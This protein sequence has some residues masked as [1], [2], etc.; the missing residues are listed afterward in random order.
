MAAHQRPC[1]RCGGS[2]RFFLVARPRNGGAPFWLCNQCRH[3]EAADASAPLITEPLRRL[4]PDEIRQAQRGYAAAAEWCAL[5]LWTPDGRPALEYLYA[6]GL[7][8]ETIHRARLGYHPD[9]YR[10]GVG[11]A[12]WHRDRDAYDGARLGGLIAPQGQPKSLLRGA[13]T[14]PY[15]HGGVC[16]LL[17]TRQLGD[18]RKGATYRSPGG[19]A[20]YAGGAP[21]LYGA[22]LLT[23]PEV[24]T[25]LLTEGEFKALLPAQHGIPAVAQPGVGY[26]PQAVVPSL[27]G[28]TVVVCYDVE[29]RR[30][31]FQMSP[32]EAWTLRAVGRLTGID[33]QERIGQTHK[34][35]GEITGK[36][37]STEEQ[38][39]QIVQ[40]EALQQQLESLRSQLEA[41][42]QLRISVKVLRLPRAPDE[43]KI[44]LDGFILRHGADALRDLVKRAEDGRLWHE[45]HHGGGY[46]Y[47]RG[48]MHNGQPVANYQAR[49]TET[50]HMCDGQETTAIQRL[51][52][53]TPSGE[54]LAVD[55]PAEEWADD[56]S[57]R[58]AIRVGLREGTF[59][60]DPRE[61][62]RAI[63]LLSNQGDPPHTRTVY[64]AT[65]WE[66]IAGRWHFLS[67]DGAIHA[68]GMTPNVRAE[69][70]PEAPGN[71]YALCAEGSAA[72]GARAW[73]RFLRGDVCPQPLALVLAAQA[74]LPLIHR[75]AGN[76]ARSMTW[77]YHQSGS[78]KTALVRATTLAL[79]GPLFTAERGDGRP[80]AKW[81]GTSTGFGL[82]VFYYRDLPVLIDDYKKDMIDEK[83]FKRFLH[84]YSEGASRSRATK[85]LGLDRSRPARCIVFSTAEDIPTG[86]PGMQA[87]LLSMELKPESVDPDALAAL[88]RAGA[89]GHLAAFWRGFVQ[90]LARALDQRGEH[91]LR[92]ELATLI[93]ADDDTLAG[94]KRAVGTLRQ[95]RLAW[96]V[97]SRWLQ[98]A[99]YL[100]AAEAQQLDAAHLETRSL[101]ASVLEARQQENRPS[102]IFLAVL[103]ELLT[104]GEL[105]VEDRAMPCPRCG[106]ALTRSSDG[107]FCTG[108][109]GE[110]ELPCTYHLRAERIIGFRC[111][112]GVGIYAN[113]AFQAV[114]RVRNDQR[115]S[116][117]YSSGAIWQ[118]LEAD[119]ALVA[120]DKKRG[121]PTVTRRN[122]AHLGADGK[123]TPTS[124]LLL[125]PEALPLGDREAESESHVQTMR[126]QRS[127]DSEG[128]AAQPD[129]E[130]WDDMSCDPVSS[131]GH[132]GDPRSEAPRD[133][134]AQDRRD[135]T[136]S[137]ACDPGFAAAERAESQQDR[138][139]R[140]NLTLHDE[141]K[142]TQPVRRRKGGALPPGTYELLP[143]ESPDE[144]AEP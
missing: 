15:W 141:S 37:Q 76:A 111:A 117:T 9:T 98:T 113:K 27:A 1:P 41:L 124:V 128:D 81:D 107:W 21:T 70:D 77:L 105:V 50:V 72:E 144:G 12:L 23:D 14:I 2:D 85:L 97:L 71:H 73:L 115:Q 137:H 13:I 114:S 45:L 140:M 8:A 51:A 28:K 122:P 61:V 102:Q 47:D 106:G 118:Q 32:G 11:P 109:V 10:D 25:V 63:R 96:L 17:R 6:R 64:T 108:T 48:G 66:A 104:S 82:V 134:P 103:A 59:D 36:K 68:E 135:D 4:T 60:D 62:L 33:L 54:R 139:D 91:G 127:R 65:G 120:T 133:S 43:P 53:Q 86:D 67:S 42:Q 138:R 34:A 24:R 88:Q 79:Y 94:H 52:L 99:G 112:D 39:L 56:R 100:S 116:F 26:L 19:V 123:G 110:R 16:T 87:R 75:F 35:L 57:A 84:N 143:L 132:P 22:D 40:L 30:D 142:N 69:I 92:A 95:N 101:L 130:S 90:E 55:V 126:S 38:A 129:A 119:G 3:Y 80:V 20:L 58:Q 121:R 44:D 83:H 89:A 49:I 18:G 131:H 7:S 93:S 29:G 74:A 46:R 78:L 125:H 136:G 31:P 5:Y